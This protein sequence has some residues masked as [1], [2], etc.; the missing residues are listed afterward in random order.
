MTSRLLTL[1]ELAIYLRISTRSIHRLISSNAIPFTRAGG[2]Y[3]F[4]QDAIDEWIKAGG[5]SGKEGG[6]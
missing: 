4:D 6:R 3:R 1:K 5:H 2:V